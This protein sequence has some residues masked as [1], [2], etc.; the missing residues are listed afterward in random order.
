MLN[1]ENLQF[2]IELLQKSNEN[3]QHSINSWK[4]CI[5]NDLQ[6]QKLDEVTINVID[7]RLKQIQKLI[8][9]IEKNESQIRLIQQ[10]IKG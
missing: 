3:H 10:I 9:E 7:S 6:S 4:E 8:T 2:G 1:V 5:I